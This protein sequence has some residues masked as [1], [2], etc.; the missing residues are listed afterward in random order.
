MRQYNLINKESFIGKTI[1]SMNVDAGYSIDFVF[2]DGTSVT[3]E[4]EEMPPDI[5][6]YGVVDGGYCIVEKKK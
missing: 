5:G 1:Q 2:T 4:L 3:L 6:T